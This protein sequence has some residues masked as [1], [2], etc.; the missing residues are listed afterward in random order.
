MLKIVFASVKTLKR[1]YSTKYCICIFPTLNAE[2]TLDVFII[3]NHNHNKLL[4]NYN[5]TQLQNV[6]TL[7]NKTQNVYPSIPLGLIFIPDKLIMMSTLPGVLKI[8]TT[9]AEIIVKHLMH[10]HIVPLTILNIA[11]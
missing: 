4:I 5:Y 9:Q 11:A 10:T 6:T 1:F 3:I 2:E 8:N 7:K